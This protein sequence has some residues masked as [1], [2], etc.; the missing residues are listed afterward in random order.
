MIATRVTWWRRFVLIFS[1]FEDIA[2]QLLLQLGQCE[3]AS[4]KAHK[5]AKRNGWVTDMSRVRYNL[6]V[7]GFHVIW[8]EI[9][10]HDLKA[11]YTCA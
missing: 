1:V 10:V 4:L 11:E 6:C 5:E 9:V 8:W 7:Y 2:S 3:P